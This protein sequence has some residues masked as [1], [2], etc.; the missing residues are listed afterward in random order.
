MFKNLNGNL[1]LLSAM[2]FL[3]LFAGCTGLK[4]VSEGRHL[5]TG[6]VME[7]DSMHFLADPSAALTE[8]KGL[9]TMRPNRK[10]LWMRPYLSLHHMLPEPKKEK[11]FKHWLKYKLGEPPAII[12]DI[13]LPNTAAAIENR[14]QN[15]GNFRAKAGFEQ[16]NKAKTA[17]VRFWISPGKPYTLKSVIY[18]EG[19]E[20]IAAD[21]R[22]LQAESI[23]KQGEIYNLKDLESERSRIDGI[24]KEKGYFYFK[25]DYLLFT[26][27][28]TVGSRTMNSW[29][30][31]KP[32][33][34]AEASRSYKLN[35]I[36]V[37]DDFTL[38]DY[39][40]D[41]T[42]IGNYYY[43]SEKHQ[44]KPETILNAIFFEKDSLYSRA[45]HYST[46]RHLMSIGVYKYAN[47][48]FMPDNSLPG[49]MNVNIALTPVKKISLSTELS[50]A[51]KSN[52]FAGP[53]LSL[54]YKNRNTFG[55]A[56]LLAITLGGNVEIQYSGE[57]K[58]QTSYEIALNS[59]LTLPKFVPFT[60]SKE[61]SKTYV[62]KTILSAGG[63]IFS[64]VNLYELHSVNTSVGY[65]WKSSENISH[66]LTP[67]EIS[68]TDLAESSA[69]FEDFLQENPTVRK[70][71]EEQ[72]IIGSSYNFVN[73]RFSLRNPI[74]SFTLNETVDVAGNLT[75]L[76][77]T[78][79]QGS[80]PTPDDQYKLLGVVYSQFIRFRNEVKYFYTPNKQN[81]IAW[82]LIAAA[83]IPY[84]NSSTIPYIK[85]YYVGGSSSIRAFVARSIGPGTYH[86]P[87]SISNI[88]VDQA[89]DIKLESSLEYRFNIY[90]FL[91][92]ALFADAGNIW[93][94]NE[95]SARSGGKFDINTFFSEIA[96]GSGF[97]FR[98]DFNYIVLRIDLAFPLRKPYLPEGER[99]VFDKIDFGSP[100]WRHDNILWNIAIGYPF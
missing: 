56:E 11:G 28:T 15:R 86:T 67:L 44:F 72:F 73:N 36:Y 23:L 4:S 2:L 24:L 97:G 69:E 38:R 34:P 89:G 40:P 77:A 79:I 63:G 85:Q 13:N 6:Q 93:L 5:Y 8:L 92:G 3:A 12:E 50:A 22:K 76:L 46:L 96:M 100:S 18:P 74:H 98:F 9:I 95:D 54:N 14:L 52:N 60:L 84:M 29:L 27:D 99:W 31:L 82:R 68:Y 19:K 62:P 90:K 42:K 81:Q 49:K 35:N 16:R 10:F 32:E 53:G 83:A 39:H 55:G 21:I 71:F 75:S 70:S 87:D 20:G 61:S 17:S 65:N 7:I 47:A 41:T 1:L 26:I 94:V 57:S 45:D 78:V 43:V 88:Y 91:K 51:I 64:R 33:M 25:P 59:S 48:R 30:N 58:G 37:L 66:Q 80:P